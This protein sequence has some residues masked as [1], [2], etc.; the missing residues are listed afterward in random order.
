MIHPEAEPL[1][2]RT[3]YKPIDL[4]HRR[5]I[6]TRQ[7]VADNVVR[8]PCAEAYW[9]DAYADVWRLRT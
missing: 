4:R 1:G 3:P 8:E 5:E 6:I 7:Q 2:N 9:Y